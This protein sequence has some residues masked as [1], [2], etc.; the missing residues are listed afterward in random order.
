MC[1]YDPAQS[2]QRLKSNTIATYL[3]IC[4][5]MCMNLNWISGCTRIHSF[6]LFPRRHVED[7]RNM[8]TSFV[9]SLLPFS[10]ILALLTVSV[11]SQTDNHLIAN[12][13]TFICLAANEIG[14]HYFLYNFFTNYKIKVEEGHQ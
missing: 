2:P 12:G 11:H 3:V 4:P 6:A 13:L 8:L 9:M 1:E 7:N 14:K 5:Y 10:R